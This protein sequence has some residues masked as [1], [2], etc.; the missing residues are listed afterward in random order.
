MANVTTAITSSFW[1][2]DT[3]W[4]ADYN[5]K[6][7]YVNYFEPILKQIRPLERYFELHGKLSLFS[8]GKF[9][10]FILSL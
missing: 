7:Y 3:Q 2:S 5:E 6:K 8:R 4:C 9:L 1:I 10:K